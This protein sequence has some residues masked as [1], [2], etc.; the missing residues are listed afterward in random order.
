MGIHYRK[1]LKVSSFKT[2]PTFI[3]SLDRRRR[4]VI[5]WHPDWFSGYNTCPWSPQTITAFQRKQY[6]RRKFVAFPSSSA[7]WICG[8]QRVCAWPP[9]ILPNCLGTFEMLQWVDRH[10][11]LLIAPQPYVPSEEFHWSKKMLLVFRQK[12]NL[13]TAMIIRRQKPQLV[14]HNLPPR[15]PLEPQ[16]DVN[17]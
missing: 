4:T 2:C 1:P 5:H 8:F 14:Q 7:G 17:I 6:L 15:L 16:P 9:W 12:K 11:Y 13:Q 3:L 10:S